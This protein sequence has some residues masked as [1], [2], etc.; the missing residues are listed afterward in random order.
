MNNFYKRFYTPAIAILFLIGVCGLTIGAVIGVSWTKAE[1][2]PVVI[3]EPSIGGFKPME[4]SS[5]GNRW[6]KS[7]VKPVLL[8]KPSIGGFVPREGSSIGNRWGKKDVLPVMLVDPSI[9][10]FVPLRPIASGGE[11]INGALQIIPITPSVIE[12][13]IDGDFEGWEGETIV[14]L[15]NRQI[16]QQSEY[17]Y[18]YHYAFMPEVLIFKSGSGYKMWVEGVEKAVRVERLK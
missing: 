2:T 1:V 3:V 16:W 7:Q 18:H 10:G 15:E 8:V 9:R 6:S 11:S 17:H 4:G 13:R 14:K 12:N 5:I